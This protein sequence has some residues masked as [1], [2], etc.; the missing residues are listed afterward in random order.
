MKKTMIP[1]SRE[2]IKVGD[3]MRFMYIENVWTKWEKEVYSRARIVED[4]DKENKALMV[5]DVLP[6]RIMDMKEPKRDRY[7]DRT[8][9]R[10]KVLLANI[11]NVYNK[12]FW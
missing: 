8:P 11:K 1:F 6:W 3:K 4:I 9:S 5:H 12:G 2:E 10:R 7:I